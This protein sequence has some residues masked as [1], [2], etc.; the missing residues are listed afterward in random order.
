MNYY[1]VLV[2]TKNKTN[3]LLT[4]VSESE[5]EPRRIVRVPLRRQMRPGLVWNKTSAR[6][7]PEELRKKCRSIDSTGPYCLPETLIQAV[8]ELG[9]NSSLSLSA[10]AQL[11]LSNAPLSK[12]RKPAL[13]AETATAKKP[14]LTDGQAA[15][16]RAITNAGTGRPQLLLGVNG[17]GK[18]RLYAELI[19][20]QLKAGR[21]SLI[22]VPE[23]GLSRQVLEILRNYLGSG[24]ETFH[25]QLTPGARKA[26][27]VKCLEHQQ[28]LVVVGARSAEFLPFKE[29]GLI[30]LDEFHDDSFKQEVWP[31][32]H[33]LSLASC[34]AKIHQAQLVCGSATP[35]VED[36]Y[37]FLKARYPVH[38]LQERALAAAR[39]PRVLIVDKREQKDI[40]AK[41]TLAAAAATLKRGCQLLI[42]YNR[43][44]DWRLAECG[45]C[46]WQAECPACDRHLVFHRDKFKLICHACGKSQKPVSVCPECRQAVRYGAIGLKAVEAEL[47]KHLTEMN[48]RF[49]IWRF[50][51]DNPKEETLSARLQTI[52]DQP[53]AL[54][55]TQIIAQGLDLPHLQTVIILDAE[56]SL[57]TPDYRSQEK[58]YRQV[59]QLSGRVGRGHL[60]DTQ[61]IVQSWQPDSPV[62]RCAIQQDWQGFYR[63]EISQRREHRLPPF[64]HLANISIRRS[65][66][67]SARKTAQLLH[68]QLSQR[69]AKVKFY[70]P[71]PA[72]RA[73][74]SGLWEWLIHA[75]APNRKNLLEVATYFKDQ[76]YFFNLDPT[77]LF[78]SGS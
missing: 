10:L 69:F 74:R 53:L 33:S 47:A 18:T 39:K 73:K 13:T 43:R 37:H 68:R 59:H 6:A 63:R 20:D 4:Y 45:Q 55:G 44:G 29:L 54:I 67:A 11:L 19:A 62:L 51:S 49:P 61:V 78:A 32:Y 72:L 1:E 66:E 56:Q 21:S 52:K 64:V 60:D 30:V 17:S 41:E 70:P 27:W 77:E 65:N 35:R 57:L 38:H 25:S 3:Q 15:V 58:Y 42:F 9:K 22:L 12:P 8:W 46:F 71:A 28:P 76:E 7:M 2:A 31:N 23:I 40:F 36:Y 14:A 34:L 26:V 50:D 48:L 5:L 24:I 75:C 16:Y